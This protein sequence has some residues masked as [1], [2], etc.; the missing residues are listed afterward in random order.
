MTTDPIDAERIAAEMLPC[1][2]CIGCWGGA[3]VDRHC[4]ASYRPAV[5]AALAAKDVE[6]AA[7][8]ELMAVVASDIVGMVDILLG[9]EF[10]RRHLSGSMAEAKE[11]AEFLRQFSS[12]PTG[13]I[14]DL[15]ERRASE[16]AAIKAELDAALADKRRLE[17]EIVALKKAAELWTLKPAQTEFSDDLETALKAEGFVPT[18]AE[19]ASIR[20]NAVEAGIE[21]AG[22]HQPATHEMIQAFFCYMTKEFGGKMADWDWSDAP[23]GGYQAMRRAA[24]SA[25]QKEAG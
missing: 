22:E 6:I 23:L 15:N 16:Y 25:S 19:N 9:D 2:D 17:A 18:L 1:T 3:H 10:I 14:G 4:A 8:S 13:A 24:L 20:G 21:A 7:G 11:T 5:A 12:N